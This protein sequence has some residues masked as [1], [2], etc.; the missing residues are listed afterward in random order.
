[1]IWRNSA[2]R[3]V[4]T[5]SSVFKLNQTCF[6]ES[7]LVMRHG[8]LSMTWK[9]CSQRKS[10]M[11]QTTES[12]TVKSLVD[13]NI[14]WKRH[15]PLLV[16]A[17]GLDNQSVNLQDPVVYALHSVGKETTV[18]AGQIVVDYNNAPAHNALIIKLYLAEI[19]ITILKQLPYP[20]NLAICD[21]F[22]FPKPKGSYFE[23]MEAI[24]RTVTTE[25]WGI[26]E[27]SFQQY[28]AAWQ[29]RMRK[30]VKTDYFEEEVM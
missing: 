11:S 15:H 4:W 5:S 19:N 22:L 2:C 18:V 21:F 14:W 20:P 24:K 13:H 30:W 7:S 27:E 3:C 8:F 9:P 12:K 23:D 17:T 25:L 16:L 6:I 1:M 10:L 29:G 28:Q 26:P